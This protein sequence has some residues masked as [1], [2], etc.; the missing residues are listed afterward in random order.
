MTL[1]WSHFNYLT[2]F[3]KHPGVYWRGALK[4]K[5]NFKER[6]IIHMKFQN[7]VIFFSKITRNTTAKL[8]SVIYSRITS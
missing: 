2:S 6:G 5:R 1:Q 7:F 4:R 3:N 8:Y